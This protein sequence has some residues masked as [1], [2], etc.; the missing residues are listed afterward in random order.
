MAWH[1]SVLQK[2][3]NWEGGEYRIKMEFSEDYPLTVRV[4]RMKR[5]GSTEK[6]LNAP[7]S[8]R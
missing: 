4:V 6:A 8:V 2:G 7:R 5:L 3:T 1:V